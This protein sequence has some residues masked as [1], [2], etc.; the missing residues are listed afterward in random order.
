LENNIKIDHKED[1]LKG[2]D[3]ITLAEAETSGRLL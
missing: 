2:L 3:V 1:E